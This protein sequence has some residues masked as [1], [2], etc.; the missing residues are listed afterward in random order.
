MLSKCLSKQQQ[1]KNITRSLYLLRKLSSDE[2]KLELHSHPRHFY[3]HSFSQGWGREGVGK[4]RFYSYNQP[5]L[6]TS[7]NKKR[8]NKIQKKPKVF[9]PKE[10]KIRDRSS[11]SG[12]GLWFF[13]AKEKKGSRSSPEMSRGSIFQDFF[14][15]TSPEFTASKKEPGWRGLRRK[16]IPDVGQRR[17]SHRLSVCRGVVGETLFIAYSVSVCFFFRSLWKIVRNG[18]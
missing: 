2:E 1:Y 12:Q 5:Q 13:R 18:L 4:S 17:I 10:F 6:E 16:S 14:D 7:K 8:Q 3:A 11:F 15:I 9:Q